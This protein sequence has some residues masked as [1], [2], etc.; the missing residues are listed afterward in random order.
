MSIADEQ[1]IFN[2]S[3]PYRFAHTVVAF[4]VT[5]GFVVLGV[6]AHFM[7]RRR[8]VEEARA[9]LSATLWLLTILVPFQILIG[10]QHGL[11]SFEHQPAKIAAI[12]ANWETRARSRPIT[13]P[14]TRRRLP[15]SARMRRT[16]TSGSSKPSRTDHAAGL[17]GNQSGSS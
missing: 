15:R 3:F 4:Y 2:P 6:A 9:M 13:V 14:A 7:L 16:A 5:T 17:F 11:N 8:S 10:D 12:E 1:I